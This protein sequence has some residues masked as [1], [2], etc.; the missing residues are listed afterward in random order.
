MNERPSLAATIMTF[1]E[2]ENIQACLDSVSS[3]V[4]EIIVLDSFS[5]DATEEICRRNPKVKFSQHG[6]DGF[7]QQANRAMEMCTADW[8]LAI[9]ADER[10]TPQLRD[11]IL[12]FLK[13]PADTIAAKFPRLTYHMHRHIRHG[14]WYPNARYRLFKNGSAHWGGKNPHHHLIISGKG[15]SLKGDLLHYSV[16]DLSDQINT[17]NRFS[18]IAALERYNEGKKFRLVRMLWKPPVKFVE[19]YFWKSGWRDGMQGFVIAV[20]SS[21]STLLKEAKLYELDVLKSDKPSNLS[22]L[23]QKRR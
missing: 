8:I 18:S 16:K 22:D 19:L 10:V 6:F 12:E 21:F 14:G 4:D 17:V 7:A 23:Y 5:T 11:S 1:N 2:E 9:D 13:D 15:A 3:W 20:S